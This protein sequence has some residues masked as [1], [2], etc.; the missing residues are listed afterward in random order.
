MRISAVLKTK[1][2]DD[3]TRRCFEKTFNSEIS[4]S[5]QMKSVNYSFNYAVNLLEPQLTK[6]EIKVLL[7]MYFCEVWGLS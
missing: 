3:V 4:F 7:L 5:R 2:S 6:F 1:A